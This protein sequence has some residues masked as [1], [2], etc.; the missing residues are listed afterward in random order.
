MSTTASAPASISEEVFETTVDSQQSKLT[1]DVKRRL[2]RQRAAALLKS[3]TVRSEEQAARCL[4]DQRETE[5]QL[6]Q[7]DSQLQLSKTESHS[8]SVSAKRYKQD[9]QAAQTKARELAAQIS[10]KEALVTEL[11]FQIQDI[12]GRQHKASLDRVSAFLGDPAN[13]FAVPTARHGA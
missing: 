1:K 11:Q 7:L 5:E 9:K 4:Q 3:A 8:F 6:R 12:G 10:E 13:V 2:Q